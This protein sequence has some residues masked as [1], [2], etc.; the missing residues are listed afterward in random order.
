MIEVVSVTDP[1]I[2]LQLIGLRDGPKEADV[3][4]RTKADVTFRIILGKID[5]VRSFQLHRGAEAGH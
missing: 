5:V 2:H 3:G 4:A 1:E